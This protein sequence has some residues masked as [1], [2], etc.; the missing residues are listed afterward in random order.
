MTT[1]GEHRIRTW[2]R[3]SEVTPGSA[4]ARQLDLMRRLVDGHLTGPDFA[5]AWLAARRDLLHG[6]E[7][8]REPFERALSEVFYLLDDYPIDPALRSPGDTTDEQ[9]H[10]GVRDALAKLADLER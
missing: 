2:R 9:L 5:R 6:G 7:R 4:V 1:H 10:Q 3:P 8:V